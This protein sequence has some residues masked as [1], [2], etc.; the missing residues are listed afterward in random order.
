MTD[1]ILD[2]A[3]VTNGRNLLEVGLTSNDLPGLQ[4]ANGLG[5]IT[6][7][8]NN[9]LVGRRPRDNVFE[10]LNSQ[11][12]TLLIQPDRRDSQNSVNNFASGGFS[13]PYQIQDGLMAIGFQNNSVFGDISFSGSLSATYNATFSGV[14]TGIT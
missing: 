6:F 12:N 1:Q 7:A 10:G 3:G 14:L 8:T 4:L 13:V 5:S 11:S 2:P 9:A